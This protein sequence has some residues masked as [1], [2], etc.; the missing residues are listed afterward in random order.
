MSTGGNNAPLLKKKKRCERDVK[1][2][3]SYQTQ[4]IKIIEIKT[5]LIF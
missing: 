4:C 1:F 3:K 2:L 5:F